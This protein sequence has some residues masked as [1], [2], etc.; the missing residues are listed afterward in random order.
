[1]KRSD[2]KRFAGML[3]KYPGKLPMVQKELD[4][5]LKERN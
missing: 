2:Q 5:Y 3:K 4:E 1:M